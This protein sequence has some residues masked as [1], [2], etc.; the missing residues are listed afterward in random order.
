MVCADIASVGS[1]DDTPLAWLLFAALGI[2]CEGIT[3]V[4]SEA[5]VL[6]VLLLGGGGGGGLGG[7]CESVILKTR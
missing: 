6:G 1:A 7:R 3:S 2:V 4:A 5:T